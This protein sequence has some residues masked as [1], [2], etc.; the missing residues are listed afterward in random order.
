MWLNNEFNTSAVG[1]LFNE[2]PGC[3][4]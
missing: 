3:I 2:D 4:Q 1:P